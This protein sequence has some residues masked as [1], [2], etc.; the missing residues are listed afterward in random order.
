MK[1]RLLAWA[2]IV[3]GLAL[4]G[5]GLRWIEAPVWA[6][7][8]AEQPALRLGSAGAAVGQGVTLGVL[9]GFRAIVADFVWIRVYVIWETRDLPATDTL[10]RLVTA[11]DPRPLYFWLNGARIVA[12][13]MTAWRIVAAGGYD[14]VPAAQ[15][16]RI[17]AEQGRL[18]VA[19]L[20]AARQF[21]PASADL[22]IERANIELHRL[23][24]TAA[25]A[26]S[27]RR[28][29]EQP[30]APYYAARLHAEMLR[31]LG[32]KAEALAWLVG[33]HPRLPRDDESACADLVLGRIREL[34]R[35][36]AVPL[37]QSYQ[38]VR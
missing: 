37:A 17:G 24:D 6:A 1:S 16:E 27:Y 38:P 34:E 28:A 14:A 26:A 12:H 5:G 22:W 25:A 21:H 11:L 33:Q 30:R 10:L 7:V 31:R 35:D 18:A 13:D 32:R 3:G 29:A 19:R 15:Q 8:R 36:L 4:T 20:D 9:G 23:H 2:V